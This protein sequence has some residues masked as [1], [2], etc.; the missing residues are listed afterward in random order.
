M[1]RSTES[2]EIAPKPKVGTAGPAVRHTETGG[3]HPIHG[4]KDGGN[5]G[6][7]SLP[8][9]S[10]SEAGIARGQTVGCRV[11]AKRLEG[12]GPTLRP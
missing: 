10:R 12:L 4:A 3:H 1:K 6:E 9:A 7:A 11:G 8:L 5:G 2:V